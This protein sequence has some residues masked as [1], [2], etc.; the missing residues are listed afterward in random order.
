MDP[1]LERILTAASQAPS[2][3][4]CQPWRFRVLGWTIELHLN[5]ESDQSLYG[6]GQR[7]SYL[8]CGAALENLVIAAT[9]EGY[10]SRVALLPNPQNSLHVATILLEKIASLPKDPLADAISA[11]CTNRKPYAQTRLSP[12]EINA[13]EAAVGGE[14]SDFF[15]LITDPNHVRDLGRVGSTNEELM[16]ANEKLHRFFFSH[17]TWTKEEDA[18]KK[19]GFYI[20]TLELPGPGECVFGVIRRW[21]VMRLLRAFGFN[22]LVAT[23][24]ARTNASVAA[25]GGL[26]IKGIEPINFVIL[27]RT[28][29][30]VWLA[31]TARGLSFQPLTGILFFKL[32]TL[33]GNSPFSED[34]Q[35]RINEAYARAVD[36]FEVPKGSHLAFVFR[37]GH[38][39]PP[40]ARSVRFPI[41]EITEVVS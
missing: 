21:P 28:V 11:R 13:L 5:A 36:I 14:G 40:S 6:W 25:I 20:K 7:A 15:E 39:T 37:V 30:R 32:Q 24:N 38:G 18:R 4:N 33:A 9:A 1:A 8:A 27:G 26:S 12:E 23:Q 10:A 3:E 35:R 34:E 41:T 2:G 29:E 17:V 31:A 19:I 22:R 16:L